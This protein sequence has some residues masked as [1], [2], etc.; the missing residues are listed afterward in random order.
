MRQLA[1]GIVGITGNPRGTLAQRSDVALVYGPIEEVCPLGLAPSTSTT[2]MIAVGDA[3]AFVLC[4][5]RDFTHEDFARFHPA[6]SLQR[7]RG[8]ADHV[9]SRSGHQG[10]GR[11]PAADHPRPGDEGARAEREDDRGL[12]R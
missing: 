5:M 9:Q 1:M 12:F 10:S 3:L 2:A 8:S 4:R 11:R 7:R 6:G